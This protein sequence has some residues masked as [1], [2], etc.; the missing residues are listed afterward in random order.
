MNTLLASIAEALTALYGHPVG[1]DTALVFVVALV[2]TVVMTARW[3]T[4][5]STPLASGPF[6]LFPLPTQGWAR[7]A[8]SGRGHN[9]ATAAATLLMVLALFVAWGIN[10]APLALGA[11]VIAEGDIAHGLLYTIL[12]YAWIW[13]FVALL[14][15]WLVVGWYQYGVGASLIA[16][17]LMFVL[18]S[19]PGWLMAG[20]HRSARMAS[21]PAPRVKKEGSAATISKLVVAILLLGSA[22][23]SANLADFTPLAGPATV[24]LGRDLAALAVDGDHYFIDA[25]DTRQLMEALGNPPT[26]REL[27]TILPKTGS[28]WFIVLEWEETGYVRDDEGRSLDADALLETIRRGTGQANEQRR[29]GGHPA[30]QVVGWAEK[31]RYDRASRRLVWALVGRPDDEER[32]IINYNTR[33]LGR[34]GLISVSLVTDAATFAEAREIVPAIVAGIS[35]KPG[36]RYEEFV[37]GRD[38]VAEYGLAAIVA[39]GA[40]AATAPAAPGGQAARLSK[41]LVVAALAAAGGLLTWLTR[42]ATTPRRSA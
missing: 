7:T 1:R 36:Q 2:L 21:P 9:G 30:L 12:G 42:L 3:K 19:V 10:L 18:L 37:R 13:A 26:R 35:F 11:T 6:R 24:D 14:P 39:G 38:R 28:E 27:G 17:S 5:R 40:G 32:E 41:L 4:L 29:V 15:I 34:R 20:A 16:N 33:V 23:A 31:P 22:S 25:E 8:A